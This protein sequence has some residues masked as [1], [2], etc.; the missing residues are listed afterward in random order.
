MRITRYVLKEVSASF[1]VTTGI[2]LFIALSNRFSLY[3]S[4]AV[5]GVLPL[6][7]IIK[8]MGLHIPELLTY[9]LPLSFF[10]ALLFSYGRLHVDNEMTVL[11]ACGIPWRYFL[12]ITGYYATGVALLVAVLGLIIVP[13]TA[14]KREKLL[15]EGETMGMMQA[16][17]PGRFQSLMG[18]KT[19]FYLENTEAKKQTMQGI[20]IA[21][22]LSE[23]KGWTLITAEHA[24]LHTDQKTG[25]LYLVLF[26]GHRYQGIPGQANYQI[27]DFKEYGR[28]IQTPQETT[29]PQ[30]SLR[31][32][33]NT[34]LWKSQDT[35]DQAELQWRLSF[36]ISVWVLA[37]LAIPLAQVRPR[38]GR[39]SNLLPALLIFILYYNSF[40][41][42][43]RWVAAAVLPPYLGVWWV[44]GIFLVLGIILYRRV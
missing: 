14:D 37:L 5:T 34:F 29:M 11:F 21:D 2:L 36:P 15:V 16:L 30:A 17:V 7:M 20:L 32:K 23:G 44:H 8:I 24:K 13:M 26:E 28:A 41:V 6:E 3:L 35:D 18:G 39:F 22:Q 31:V 27:M 1:C 12:R 4:K 25:E 9:L 40:T 10:I 42:V 19:V 43:R 33:T 38:Q